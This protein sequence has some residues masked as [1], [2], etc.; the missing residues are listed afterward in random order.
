MPSVFPNTKCDF[1]LVALGPGCGGGPEPP[2]VWC[3]QQRLFAN[4]TVETHLSSRS[5]LKS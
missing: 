4:L 2:Q 5:R 3:G 1:A